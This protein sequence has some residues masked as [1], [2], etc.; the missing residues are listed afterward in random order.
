MATI[1]RR[2]FTRAAIGGT[3]ALAT[4]SAIAAPAISQQR[5]EWRM[6]TSWPK[7]FPGGGTA[8]E[9]FAQTIAEAT[10]GRLAIKVFA[11]DE[12]VPAFEAFDA[13]RR[14]AAECMHATPYYWQDKARALS[15][16][17][18]VPFGMSNYESA[19]WLRYGG[20][21]ELWDEIYGGFGLKG[22]LAGST[23]VQM[24]GWFN[25]EIKSAADM[26]GLRMRIPGLGGEALR[27]LGATIVNLPVGEI[28]GALQSGTIDAIEWVGPWQDLAAG[29]YKV[30]KYYYW[31]GMHEPASLY[32]ISVNKAKWDALP[33]DVQRIFALACGDEYVQLTA[34]GDASNARA[35]ATLVG[36]HKVQLRRLPDDFLQA[37]GKAWNEVLAELRDSG[38]A[39]EK[40]I[41]ES[42]Y[43][44][45]REQ[46]AWTRIGM[47]EYLNGRQIGY[48]IN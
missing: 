24:A 46:M 17:T 44:F 37:Y 15:V 30:A 12:L 25:K 35:L 34:E 1:R 31:P 28:L 32:E 39:L 4:V 36:Q 20:G 14:G 23:G 21:Q 13:V 5:Q 3:A 22:F 27:K 48:K 2:R 29:Y 7:Q 18:T 47:Q 9:R 38:D 6:V 16:F 45:Q 41:L 42:Y 26:K 8:A 19:A 11:A 10:G 40:R 33:S 43:K